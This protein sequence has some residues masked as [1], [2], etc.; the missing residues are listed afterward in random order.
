MLNIQ[1]TSKPTRITLALLLALIA[2]CAAMGAPTT[3]LAAPEEPPNLVVDPGS[4]DFGLQPVYSG[5]QAGFQLRNEGAEAI[6]L[7][8]SQIVGD[9][10]AFWV[11]DCGWK[12]LQPSETCFA[13]VYFNPQHAGDF[14]A[15]LRASANGYQF[16]ATLSGEGGQAIFAPESNPVDFGV[17]KVGAGVTREIAVS[18]LGNMAGGVFIAVVSGGAIGSYQLLDESCTGFPLAPAATCTLQVR[19]EPLSEGVKKATLS[20]F[21]E[22]DGGA[23]IALSGVGAAPDPAPGP[24]SGAG[25]VAS[26]GSAATP[27]APVAARPGPKARK[28][29]RKPRIRRHGRR[30]GLAAARRIAIAG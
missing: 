21:G 8:P 9:S 27:A 12:M 5:S 11:N 23:Q 30:A 2:L 1:Q 16:S 19:F 25:E 13:Q 10:S 26:S 17:A 14:N 29:K 24:V 3:A 6:Q 28:R 4:H 7:E 22:G 15:E 18:N 20:L